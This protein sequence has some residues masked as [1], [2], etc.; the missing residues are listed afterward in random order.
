M[1]CDLCNKPAVVH[2]MIVKHGVQKEVHLCEEHAAASGI[3]MP[4]QQPINQILTQFVISQSQKSTPS[5]SG[6]AR[7][8]C[9]ECGLSFAMFRKHGV[10][11]CA[12]CYEAFKAQLS[13]LIE[14]AQN[15]GT[16]HVGKAPQ[17]AGTSI[18]RQL[19]RQRLIKELDAAVCAEQYERAA[20]IRDLLSSLDESG[21]AGEIVRPSSKY[22]SGD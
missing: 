14:R 16:H 6:A 18:D 21:A 12:N 17:R 4:G 5:S 3:S 15:G 20:K 10:L 7:K 19:Q 9:P 13:P 1:K 22:H 11:G 8:S 2:E